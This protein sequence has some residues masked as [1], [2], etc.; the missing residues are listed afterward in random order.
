MSRAQWGHGYYRRPRRGVAEWAVGNPAKADMFE[1]EEQY[2][3]F[4][5][6]ACKYRHDGDTYCQGC[7]HCAV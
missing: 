7:S 3:G 6:C 1:Y 5:C 2:Y 4:P